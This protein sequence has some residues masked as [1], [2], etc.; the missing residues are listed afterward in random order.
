MGKLVKVRADAKNAFEVFIACTSEES[1]DNNG[2]RG[3]LDA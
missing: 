1:G 3:Q 2:L